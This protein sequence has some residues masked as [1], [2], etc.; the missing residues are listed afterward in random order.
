M[1][2]R[3]RRGMAVIAAMLLIMLDISSAYAAPEADD[4]EPD[5][6][7]GGAVLMEK[8]TGIVLLSKNAHQK[9]PMASTTKIMTALV[10]IENCSLGETVEVASKAYG[11]EG[12]SMYLKAGEKISVEDLL[13]GLM[14]L[15]G[16]DA[17]V[18]L[19]IHTA[20]TVEAFAA[21]MN[22]RAESIGARNTHF[23]TPNGLH[24]AEHYTTAYDLALIAAEAMKNEAFRTI[25][26]STYHKSSTGSLVR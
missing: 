15:S 3:V 11:V 2:K 1:T 13:Y 16:N 6:D 22:K 24:D 7:A 5:M 17:A 26:A 25:V 18:A 23:V 12:S 21:L 20:G 4:K 9:L 19:A 10:V 8:D 14:L